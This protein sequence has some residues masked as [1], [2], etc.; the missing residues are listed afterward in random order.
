MDALRINFPANFTLEASPSAAKYS[1]EKMAAYGMNV[2]SAPASFTTRREYDFA[3]VFVLPTEFP[4]LRSFYSQFEAND[5]QSIILK[6]TAP[7]VA[8][9]AAGPPSAD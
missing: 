8:T 2:Q 9:T 3:E 4:E 7:A 1:M 5:Q 6:S